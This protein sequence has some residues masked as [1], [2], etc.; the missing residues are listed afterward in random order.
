LN[1]KKMDILTHAISGL[2]VGT[3][4]AGISQKRTVENLKIIGFSGFGAM[5]GVTPQKVLCENE[6]LSPAT[7][8]VSPR[9]RQAAGR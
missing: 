8:A 6:S 2:A 7:T 5:A 9:L 4:I 3:V 1:I